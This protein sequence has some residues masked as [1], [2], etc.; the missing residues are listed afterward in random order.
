M[1][2][3]IPRTTN[4]VSI[5]VHTL[6]I[7]FIAIVASIS[8]LFLFINNN[9]NQAHAQSPCTYYASPTGNG[10]GLSQSSPFKIADFW[11]KASPGKTLCLL[12]GTYRGS[13]SMIDP[14]DGLSGTAG[15]PI[16]V[17]ALNEGH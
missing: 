6:P 7:F 9:N 12:D 3:R 1:V 15:N 11:S 14:P 2:S 5:I 13:D 4:A 17:R 10:N 16:T 8:L